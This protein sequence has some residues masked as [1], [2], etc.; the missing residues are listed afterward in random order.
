MKN[1]K[2]QWPQPRFLSP[3]E[4]SPPANHYFNDNRWSATW[5]WSLLSKVFRLLLTSRHPCWEFDSIIMQ[6]LSYI[7]LLFWHQHDRLITWVQSKNNANF[8]KKPNLNFWQGEYTTVNRSFAVC[9]FKSFGSIQRLK[10][11]RSYY[12]E[13]S[14]K[15]IFWSDV[16][17][18]ITFPLSLLKITLTIFEAL[19]AACPYNYQ[20]FMLR[21]CHRS[22]CQSSRGSRTGGKVGA[23]SDTFSFFSFCPFTVLVFYGV[24]WLWSRNKRGRGG[25]GGASPGSA[26]AIQHFITTTGWIK[27]E[28][29]TMLQIVIFS[30]ATRCESSCFCWLSCRNIKL[31]L[32]F[33]KTIQEDHIVP[34]FQTVLEWENWAQ[35]SDE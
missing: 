21:L 10:T 2:Q 20:T 11:V 19:T 26:T 1:L 32:P 16:F 3:R 24:W 29:E 27:R 22:S 12:M 35:D 31:H 6:N 18:Y 13:K 9:T 4:W 28:I 14:R 17:L 34:V 5:F 25:G 8:V 33:T 7:F 23:R 30:L 15:L